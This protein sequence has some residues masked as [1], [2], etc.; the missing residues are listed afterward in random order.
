[1]ERE[2][3]HAEEMRERLY[4]LS[5]NGAKEEVQLSAT[6]KYLDRLEGLPVQKV[7]TQQAD[8]LTRMTD[9]QLLAAADETDSR[10]ETFE[11]LR[12]VGSQ[13]VPDDDNG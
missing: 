11:Q 1:M 6:T 12:L 8:A 9:E 13:G 7:V 10:L 4:F 3:R 2:S 5:Y